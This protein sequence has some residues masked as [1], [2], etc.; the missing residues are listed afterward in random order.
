MT[1]LIIKEQRIRIDRL[2][3][4]SENNK[5][6][7]ECTLA[8]RSL[9]MGKSWLGKILEHIGSP[10]PYKVVDKEAEIPNTADVFDESLPTLESH[11]EFVNYIRAEI[12]KEIDLIDILPYDKMAVI[13]NQ[14]YIH[15][16]EAKMW[17]GF[18][19][20]NIKRA[21]ANI[22]PNIKIQE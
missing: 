17:Y 10:T 9:Q 12:Q 6:S 7:A 1:T 19:L 4:L 21:S 14:V 13:T 3:C 20:Q 11:L 15:L 8:L 5:K 2:I 18:E 22:N 16:S